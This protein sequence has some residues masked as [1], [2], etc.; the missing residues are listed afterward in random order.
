M[1]DREPLDVRVLRRVIELNGGNHRLAARMLR[2]PMPSLY[3]WAKGAEPVPRQ[4]FFEAV[5]VLMD[6]D[7]GS[8]VIDD[9]ANDQQA[10][11]SAKPAS[12]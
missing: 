11:R 10:A 1:T 5:D 6:A 3:L 12:R 2:V 4:V 9:A 7:A 8:F